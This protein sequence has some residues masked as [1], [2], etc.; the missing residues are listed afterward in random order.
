M[1]KFDFS[2]LK[3]LRLKR[4]L[5]A[6]QL[7]DKADVTRATIA[8]METGFTNPTIQTIEALA[9]VFKLPTS[10]LVRLAEGVRLEQARVEP[11]SRPG[12]TGTRLYFDNLEIYVLRADGGSLIESDFELHEDTTEV[13]FV[14]SGRLVLTVG[15]QTIPMEPGMA[16]RF[17]AMQEHRFDIRENSE[18]LLIHYN[19]V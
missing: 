3:T 14:V 6:E 16:M 15:D 8:K 1:K 7:A 12:Y 18:F 2:V 5:T 17:S 10:D 11:F 4:G 19:F 9:G 13:C